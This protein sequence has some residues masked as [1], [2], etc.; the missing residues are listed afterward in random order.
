LTFSDDASQTPLFNFNCD[1]ES[2]YRSTKNLGIGFSAIRTHCI[3]MLFGAPMGDSAPLATNG[4]V[5]RKLPAGQF[6]LLPY[7]GNNNY[8]FR[9]ETNVSSF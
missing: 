8:S 6:I 5:T 1:R 4:G 7:Y 9:N 3:N 2:D